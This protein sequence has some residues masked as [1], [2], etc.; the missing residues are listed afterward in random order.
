MAKKPTT[1][2]DFAE[3]ALDLGF[4]CFTEGDPSPFI[5]LVF[6]TGKRDLVELQSADETIS[7]ML[8][9]Y[10]RKIIQGFEDGLYYALVWDGYLTGTGKR[11]EAVVAEIGSSDGRAFVLA[12]RYKRPKSIGPAKVGKPLQVAEVDNLW[13][14]VGNATD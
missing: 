5:L 13:N 11:Q 2:A 6:K 10:G 4:G 1:L 7:V 9:N 12:Q 14:D 8:L 3:E